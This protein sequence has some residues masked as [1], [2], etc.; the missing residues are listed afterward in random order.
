MPRGSEPSSLLG[1][2]YWKA[3]RQLPPRIPVPQSTVDGIRSSLAPVLTALNRG[4]DQSSVEYSSAVNAFGSWHQAEWWDARS[5]QTLTKDKKCW[6]I[7]QYGLPGFAGLYARRLHVARAAA[8][9]QVIIW[10][11]KKAPR[12]FL[13]P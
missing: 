2:A 7:E 6:T 10:L 11:L 9:R 5:N 13:P 3:L 1:L 8:A 4:I 12:L